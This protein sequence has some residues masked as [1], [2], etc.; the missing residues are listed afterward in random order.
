MMLTAHQRILIRKHL[1]EVREV[2]VRDDDEIVDI[3]VVRLVLGGSDEIALTGRHGAQVKVWRSRL[4][5]DYSGRVET[6]PIEPDLRER[7]VRVFGPL[8]FGGDE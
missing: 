5:G 8:N 1:P 4:V 7:L 6:F 3:A 2:H